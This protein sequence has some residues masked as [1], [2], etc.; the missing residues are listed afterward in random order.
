VGQ[1]ARHLIRR[2]L[3]AVVALPTVILLDP[4]RRVISRGYEGEPT[5]RG[6]GLLRTIERLLDGRP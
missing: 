3:R 1:N 2:H 6:E 5:I 4:E